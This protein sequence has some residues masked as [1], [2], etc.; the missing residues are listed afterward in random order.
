MPAKHFIPELSKEELQS[1][2]WRD[3]I[4][5]EGVYSVSN[6][7]RIRRDAPPLTGL[8]RHCAPG[9]ML[10]PCG[11][12]G[13]PYLIVA[14]SL[15]GESQRSH[16][17]HRLVSDAFLGPKHPD[18]ETNHKDTNKWNNRLSNLEYLSKSDHTKHQVEHGQRSRGEHHYAAK[19]TE[20]DVR[21]IR[22]LW[23]SGM[24][25]TA[26]SAQY[27]G[28]ITPDNVSRLVRRESWKHVA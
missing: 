3:V 2:K 11:E 10:K 7:G 15:P 12:A 5:Y 4:G 9:K 17:V 18:H 23:A 19:L 6:L 1:E 24:K 27:K 22:R 21:R 13:R 20:I 14:L 28:R 26:I 25:P 8:K 16:N